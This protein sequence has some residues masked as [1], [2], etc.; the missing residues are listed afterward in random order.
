MSYEQLLEDLGNL[1][2]QFKSNFI[3]FMPKLVF[4]L[5]IVIIGLLVAR[6]LQTIVNK[7]LKNVDR[8]FSNRKLIGGLKKSRLEKYSRLIGRIVFWIILIFFIT[9]A[10]EVL[11]LPIITAWFSGLV[12]YLPNILVAVIIVFL[13]IVGG[14]LLR[15]IVST[16]SSGAGLVYF[17]VLGKII[18]YTVLL[19]AILIAIDQIG[20][21]ITV[22]TN[23]IDIVLGA[24]L[25]GAALAFGLGARTSVSNILASYYIQGQYREGQIIKIEDIEGPII[26]ITNTAV[27]VDSAQGQVSIPAKQFSENI[28]TLVK[29][30][31]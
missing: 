6:L 23:V 25:F 3:S 30:E 9:A 11:G 20:V 15:D 19:L 16:A 2:T 13:G 10:T 8:L 5:F 1:V 29:K 17:S 7:S 18:Q 26:H 28:S 31:G 14:R 21:D 27:L 22:L 24:V 12:H 4:A